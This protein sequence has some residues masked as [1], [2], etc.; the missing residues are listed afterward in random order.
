MVASLSREP[1][2]A[3]RLGLD[4]NQAAESSRAFAGQPPAL[5]FP[6]SVSRVFCESGFIPDSS[7]PLSAASGHMRGCPASQQQYATLLYLGLVSVRKNLARTKMYGYISC[8]RTLAG[9][10]VSSVVEA[11]GLSGFIANRCFGRDRRLGC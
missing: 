8:V 11:S 5:R 2:P 9:F 3:Q 10:H 6:S 1:R 7:K 4:E